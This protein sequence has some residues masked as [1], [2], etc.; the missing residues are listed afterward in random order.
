MEISIPG[1]ISWHFLSSLNYLLREKIRKLER[2]EELHPF[3][4]G[5]LG[6]W[7]MSVTSLIDVLDDDFFHG[8]TRTVDAEAM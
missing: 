8:L 6:G 3:N 1:T 2:S 7:C 4:I 5:M